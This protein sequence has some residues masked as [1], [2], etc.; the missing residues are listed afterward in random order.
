MKKLASLLLIVSLC[1]CYGKKPVKT[2]LEGQPMPELD[3]IG[4]DSTTHFNTGNIPTGKTTIL[5]SFEPWCP[6]C[7]AQTEEMLKGM[8]SFKDA[9]IYML[10]GSPFPLARKFYDHYG[11]SAYPN[12]KVVVDSSRSFRK[13]FN[14]YQ[15]PFIAIYGKDKKLQQ[16]FIGRSNNKMI[17]ELVENT[18]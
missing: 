13:Y 5:F 2:G 17:E 14:N 9:N 11:L 8:K 6:F 1:A 10:C 12:I 4:L 15:I 16:A 3:L 18:N 7:K